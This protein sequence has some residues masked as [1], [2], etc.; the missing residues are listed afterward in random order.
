MKITHFVR[1]DLFDQ[2][3][4]NAVVAFGP[5]AFM[6]RQWDQRAKREIDR[7]DLVIFAKGN[8]DQD[9]VPFNGDDEFYCE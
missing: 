4:W 8:A 2:H 3:Y 6:H 9:V 5:P 7:T 1:F